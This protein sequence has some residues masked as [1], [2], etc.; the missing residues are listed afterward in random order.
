[1]CRR[2]SGPGLCLAVLEYWFEVCL[3]G[4]KLAALSKLSGVKFESTPERS[5]GDAV[6]DK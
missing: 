4:K 5:I 2:L 1:M 3:M 6:Q